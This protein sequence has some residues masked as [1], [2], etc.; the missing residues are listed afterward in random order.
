MAE[1]LF[2]PLGFKFLAEV[3]YVAEKFF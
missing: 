1:H 2:L 3:I